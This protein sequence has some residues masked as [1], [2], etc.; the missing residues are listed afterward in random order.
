[1]HINILKPAGDLVGKVDWVKGSFVM[2]GRAVAHWT[3]CNQTYA[4][5]F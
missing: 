4:V 1:M 5:P 2:I 3:P